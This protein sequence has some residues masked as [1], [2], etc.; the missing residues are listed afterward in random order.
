MEDDMNA[1]RTTA[2]PA[3]RLGRSL[4]GGGIALT[5]LALAGCGGRTPPESEFHAPAS[6]SPGAGDPDW[7]T[8]RERLPAPDTDRVEY[9]SAKRLLIFSSLPGNDRWMVQLPGETSGRIV[10]PVH[11]LPDGVDPDRTLVYYA[12]PGSKVSA[13][14]TVAQIGRAGRRTPPSSSGE[15]GYLDDS[16]RRTRLARGAPR[17]C[18]SSNSSALFRESRS[19]HIPPRSELQSPGI[20]AITIGTPFHPGE[21]ESLVAPAPGA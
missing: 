21:R 17:T 3:S 12:R 16:S 13:R 1:F 14:V 20:A 8:S 15:P 7:L 11:R 4:R 9:D 18:G 19:R 10:G 2:R 6:S 5:L